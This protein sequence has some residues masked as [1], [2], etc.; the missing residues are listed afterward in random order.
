MKAI[1][2]QAPGD[3]RQL[4]PVDI[5]LPELQTGE[6]L[7]K[8]KAISINPVDVKSRAGKGVYGR[9]KE[10]QPLILG[11]DISGE[12]IQTRSD[13]FAVG[14][15]VF[16]M[17]N[18]P[19]HGKAYAEFVAAPADQLAFKPATISHE[20]AAAATLAALTAWQVLVQRANVQTGQRVLIQSAAGGV[21][22]FAVQIAKHLG[23]HVTGTAS[24]KNKDF[25]LALGADA[26]IDYTNADWHSYGDQFDFVLDTIGGDHS[27]IMTKPGGT[28]ISIPTGLGADVIERSKAKKVDA[29]FY[30][31]QSAG[32]NMAALAALIGQGVIKPH[33]SALFP[34]EDM[35]AAHLQVETGKT[36]GKV[37]V[38][39]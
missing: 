2:V 24:G 17:V 11:W 23:A 25:V 5:A 26:Y 28:L 34:F 27:L 36:I 32:K 20:E 21:G 10:E 3:V 7:V 13:R 29:A 18:F 6:V 33:V 39:L 14:D 12:V 16:G 38:R 15:E 37:V 31:V 22:H 35:A 8:V 1:I 19:G 4:Q 9:L 30:L